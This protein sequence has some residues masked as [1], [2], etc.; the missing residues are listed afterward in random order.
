MDELRGYAELLQD[1]IETLSEISKVE[2]KGA[3]DREVKVDV[4]LP[5]MES[6]KISF[7]DISNAIHKS[8]YFPSETSEF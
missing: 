4:D 7:D 1:E 6:L 8:Y 3:L 5:K 2:L